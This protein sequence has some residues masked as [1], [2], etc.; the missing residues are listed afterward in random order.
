MMNW[1]EGGKK[2]SYP[3]FK[4]LSQQF[5]GGINENY[6]KNSV[7]IACLQAEI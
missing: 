6:K 7:K 2:R 3:N 5:P 4:V 1:K